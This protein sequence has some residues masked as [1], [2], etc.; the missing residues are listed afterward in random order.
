[1]TAERDFYYNKLLR[2]KEKLS[3]GRMTTPN[4]NTRR[5]L[6][7]NT[8]II[9]SRHVD[10]QMKSIRGSI[11]SPVEKKRRTSTIKSPKSGDSNH[12]LGRRKR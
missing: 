3:E 1:M 4:T 10:E 7:P 2:V 11:R 12:S 6:T 5:Q 9:V 8:R